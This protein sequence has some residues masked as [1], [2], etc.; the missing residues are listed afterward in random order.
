[1]PVNRTCH[2]EC[3]FD[4]GN[5]WYQYA[6]CPGST[7]HCFRL[8]NKCNYL[9]KD[10]CPNL[11]EFSRRECERPDT[12]PWTLCNRKGLVNCKGTRKAQCVAERKLCD[13]RYD[14]LDRSDE[15]GCDDGF[16]SKIATDEALDVLLPRVKEDAEGREE[17]SIYLMRE[18]CTGRLKTEDLD[19]L[20]LFT[21]CNGPY[22]SGFAIG[23]ELGEESYNTSESLSSK[24]HRPR[25]GLVCIRGYDWCQDYPR[26]DLV[27]VA[28]VCPLLTTILQ[29][30]RLCTNPNLWEGVDCNYSRDIRCSNLPGKCLEVFCMCGQR[31]GCKDQSH[32]VCDN[33]ADCKECRCRDQ[34]MWTCRDNATCVHKALI[35]D[36]HEQCADGSD[37]EEA[38]CSQ[39]PHGMS[40]NSAATFS[41]THRYT[42]RKICAVPCDGVDDLCLD[43]EDEQCKGF[44]FLIV[45]LLTVFLILVTMVVGEFLFQLEESGNVFSDIRLAS[46]EPE[47]FRFAEEIMEGFSVPANGDECVRR[48]H[49]PRGR[50]R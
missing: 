9:R 43:N 16:E 24:W 45:A 38:V 21:P 4:P 7:E 6:N 17:S 23:R 34:A 26:N 3:F 36:G 29:D 20:S 42:G 40:L 50:Q 46:D 41:C 47:W 19:I 27:D 30:R 14:C 12:L 10:S 48:R 5:P 13:G 1:M 44:G 2:G 35:C 31:C 28:R 8:Y 11:A 15:S 18:L 39:C 32:M 33:S 37:E 25:Y 22:T 49:S